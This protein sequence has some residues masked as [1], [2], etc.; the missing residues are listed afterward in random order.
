MYYERF[1]L[2]DLP[3]YFNNF[4]FKLCGQNEAYTPVGGE[5][6]A[7]YDSNLIMQI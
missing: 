3:D 6:C 2:K 4:A 1:Q 5:L 7:F